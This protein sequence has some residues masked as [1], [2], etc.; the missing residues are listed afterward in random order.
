MQTVGIDSRKREHTYFGL[1]IEKHI[2]HEELK[3]ALATVLKLDESQVAIYSY[4]DIIDNYDDVVVVVKSFEAG[5]KT[6]I[7]IQNRLRPDNPLA[8]ASALSAAL[9]TP[10]LIEA[11]GLAAICIMC[12]TDGQF[13]YVIVDE[14]IDDSLIKWSMSYPCKPHGGLSNSF[15]NLEQYS[16][17]DQSRTIID[18]FACYLHADYSEIQVEFGIL[19]VNGHQGQVAELFVWGIENTGERVFM[20][21][22]NIS[23]I[24]YTLELISVLSGGDI[25]TAKNLK[26]K[27]TMD[28]LEIEKK[29]LDAIINRV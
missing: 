10:V 16:I 13:S 22:E 27:I 21:I 20:D 8:V 14:D 1:E 19:E 26:F 4:E 3:S 17:E 5:F 6:N 18:K 28:S 25:D 24:A 2:S 23:F 15:I 12:T 29:D 11:L 9:E 7:E